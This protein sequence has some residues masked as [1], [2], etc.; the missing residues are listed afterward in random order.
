LLKVEALRINKSMKKTKV[1]IKNE[2]KNKNIEKFI[3]I[4]DLKINKEFNSVLRIDNHYYYGKKMNNKTYLVYKLVVENSFEILLEL[5]NCN[6]YLF[7]N[8]ILIDFVSLDL[9]QNISCKNTENIM[10]NDLLIGK[11]NQSDINDYDVLTL[12]NFEKKNRFID[13]YL[14]SFF[15]KELFGNLNGISN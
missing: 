8:L 7:N 3:R 1:N 12:I 2:S 11:F 9:L 4:N 13:L 10:L 14:P 15:I 5:N 6:I